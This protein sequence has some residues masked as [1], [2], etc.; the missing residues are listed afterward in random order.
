MTL[1]TTGRI[2]VNQA[3]SQIQ[4]A[5]A[6]ETG[7]W[8]ERIMSKTSLVAALTRLISYIMHNCT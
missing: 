7:S 8:F 3:L 4:I 5:I 1:N 6:G 2:L